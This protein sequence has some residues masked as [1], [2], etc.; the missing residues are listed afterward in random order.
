MYRKSVGQIMRRSVGLELGTWIGWS[1]IKC[2]NRGGSIGGAIVAI[3]PHQDS[4]LSSVCGGFS[5]FS[6]KQFFTDRASVWRMTFVLE[7]LK[8]LNHV[9]VC[10]V[11]QDL[12]DASDLDEVG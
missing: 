2:G 12:L 5:I 6:F 4:S 10:H 7:L 8:R 1:G 11:H 9:A 3:A